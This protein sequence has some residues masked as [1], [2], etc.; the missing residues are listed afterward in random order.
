[1][2]KAGTT[3]LLGFFIAAWAVPARA[4]DDSTKSASRQLAKEG[5]HDF[6]KGQFDDASRKF[7][8]AF[9]A[10][11]VPTLALWAARSLVKQGRLVAASEFFRKA[12]QLQRNELWVGKSQE[13]AQQQA[14]DELAQ[15]LPRLAQLTI[16]LK[17]ANGSEV[18][19][20]VDD[21]LVP[22]SLLGAA[23]P[24]DPGKRRI[25]AKRGTEEVVQELTLKEGE[26]R[27]VDLKFEPKSGTVPAATAALPSTGGNAPPQV[28]TGVAPNT[29]PGDVTVPNQ[30][31][32]NAQ[33]GP[34]NGSAPSDGARPAQ[35][36]A[37]RSVGW[38]SL[39]LGAAGVIVGATTGLIVKGR[40]GDYK[41]SCPNNNC[42]LSVVNQGKLDSYNTWRTVSTVSF[43][44]GAVG[45]AAGVTLLLT[46]PK[47]ASDVGLAL[48]VSPASA[49]V[50][51]SF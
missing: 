25:V 3:L 23:R 2:I 10:T 24:T 11:E 22:S 14:A 33:S 41:S 43:I 49:E 50:R 37:Q 6:D 17:G 19:V 34:T 5:K 32:K 13:Q 39:G 8:Q 18:Q 16:I 7:Q 28:A 26:P 4:I 9:A 1:M 47:Q 30:Q 21:V 38:V 46:S 42:D 44:V 48:I 12:A 40:Y 45:T 35:P 29:S 27:E 51:G 31:T 36:N 20:T 15:L